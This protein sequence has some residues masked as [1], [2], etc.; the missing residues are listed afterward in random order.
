MPR[1]VPRLLDAAR[2]FVDCGSAELPPER[3]QLLR[4]ARG[5]GLVAQAIVL[6]GGLVAWS[7]GTL[8]ICA[9]VMAA[10]GGCLRMSRARQGRYA[11]LAVNLAVGMLVAANVATAVASGHGTYPNV[12]TFPTLCVFATA[13]I[14]GIRSAAVWAGV[15]IA[16]MGMAV[17]AAP[18]V[19]PAPGTV[20]VPRGVLF[21]HN[22]VVLL[23]AFA[24]AA[25]ARR[26]EDRQSAQLAFLARHDPLTGLLNRYALEARIEEALARV[27]RHGWKAALLFVDL[28]GFK[29]V[30]DAQG[31]HA[32]DLVLQQ[33]AAR[34]REVTRATDAAARVGGD[35]FV[36]LLESVSEEKDAQTY[37]ERLLQR[38]AE[39]ID[40]GDAQV[41]VSASIGIATCPQHGSDASSLLL[42]ADAAM[43]RAKRAGGDRVAMAACSDEPRRQP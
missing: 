43:Y 27:A 36:V 39:P 30:N 33:V 42:A 26:F 17:F 35:E 12:V 28:D 21:G 10:I 16:G 6:V 24:L 29:R 32:G 34:I 22:A 23:S 1:L 19:A 2:R 15:S 9:A 18:P 13:H 38:A 25:V 8:V 14:V 31:H 40:V 11:A 5:F 3:A 37:A 20:A 41:R 4:R 7:A